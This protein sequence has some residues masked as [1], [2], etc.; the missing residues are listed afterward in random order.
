MKAPT[1]FSSGGVLPPFVD[2]WDCIK[3]ALPALAPVQRIT[4]PAAA[5]EYRYLDNPGYHGKWQNDVAPYMVEPAEQQTSRRFGGVIF[6]GP[7]RTAKTAQLIE[8]KATHT[9]VAQPRNLMIVH[10]TQFSARK[11]SLEKL[12]NMIRVSP[13]IAKRLLVDNTYD[14]TFIG[15]T[16][17]SIAWP[18][19][20]HLSGSDVPEVLL[21]DYDR[22]PEDIDGEGDAFSLAQKRTQTFGSLGNVTAESSPG[23]TVTNP[24]WTPSTP[25]EPPPTTGILDLFG[26][27]TRGRLYWPCP[28][29]R[30]EYHV[31]FDRMQWPEGAPPREAGEQAVMVCPYCGYP[32]PAQVKKELTAHSRWLHEGRNAAAWAA[33]A[34]L[35]AAD[36]IDAGI[37]SPIDGDIRS[38]SLASYWMEGPA[39]AF[40]SWA[41]LVERYLAALETYKLTGDEQKLKTTVNLDQ[42][43]AHVEKALA[44]STHMTENALKKSAISLS[45]KR[46]APN[47]A[48]FITIQ[49]DVQGTYFAVQ[50]D[51]WG[52][53]LRRALI[54]RWN[55]FKPASDTERML[56]PARYATD[57]TQLFD[58]LDLSFP[59]EGTEFAL[60]PMGLT[61]D[62]G[63]RPGVT[64]R[65]YAFWRR[66]QKRGL[67]KRVNLV[68][69]NHVKRGLPEDQRRAYVAYPERST[70]NGKKRALDVPVIWV[71]TDAL[72]DEISAALTMEEDGPG[73]YRIAA[74]LDESVFAEMAAERRTDSGWDKKPGVLRNEAFDLAVYGKALVL[75]KGGEKIDW[76]KPPNWAA[77]LD[78]NFYAERVEHGAELKPKDVPAPRPARRR[79]S[80]FVGNRSNFMGR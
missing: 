60:R 78:L 27:G 43:R 61:V 26:Q 31:G 67:G 42:G 2:P 47:W 54:D 66:A 46:S 74:G 53:G 14:K 69:G 20:A 70:E 63:G 80:S 13:E 41:Q 37:L 50:A 17:L 51:A 6:A 25:H 18:T 44:T 62:S 33:D 21:T 39:A 32:A 22:M 19:I 30:D 68:K 28:Q 75:I 57:W 1:Y 16:R 8:N 15:G 65:A 45:A 4:V 71:G 29:C 35:T 72:K 77:V 79:S 52:V 64:P 36:M 5:A 73:S 24:D 40:Q 58:L 3:A 56:D 76:S 48:R 23:R 49:V 7:A 9:I 10:M 11:F 55:I 59:V 38:T 34:N 12:D